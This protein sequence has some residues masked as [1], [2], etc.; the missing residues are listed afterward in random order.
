MLLYQ[1][2]LKKEYEQ[3]DNFGLKK[4]KKLTILEAELRCETSNR[5]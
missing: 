2:I 3:M 5:T 4:T 1:S